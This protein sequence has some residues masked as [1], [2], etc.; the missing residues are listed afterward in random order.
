MTP[1]KPDGVGREEM[2]EILENTL[3]HGEWRG[4][5][6]TELAN[7]KD[8]QRGSSERTLRIEEKVQ[9]IAAKVDT[10]G[11]RVAL[12]ASLASIIGGAI[13][14]AVIAWVMGRIPR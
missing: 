12:W 4:S 6:S 2:K 13:V 8:G 1:V 3:K 10:L 9:S 7:L 14:S 5:V 11:V